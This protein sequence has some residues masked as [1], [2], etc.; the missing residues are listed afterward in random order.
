MKKR[1]QD[2]FIVNK[3][4]TDRYMKSSIPSMQR[5]LNNYERKMTSALNCLDIVSNDLYPRD[6][7]VGKIKPTNKKNLL[8]SGCQKN[9]NA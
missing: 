5:L 2:K 8:I 7:L 9:A 1:S 6:S 3:A 4:K